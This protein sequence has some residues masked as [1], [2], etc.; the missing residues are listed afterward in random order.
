MCSLDHLH[1]DDEQ[2]DEEDE[3]HSDSAILMQTSHIPLALSDVVHGAGWTRRDAA[4]WKKTQ[5]I[6]EL[7]TYHYLD[8]HI[9][10]STLTLQYITLSLSWSWSLLL[11]TTKNITVSY[12][13]S[14]RT[15]DL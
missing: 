15:A 3:Q 2:Q 13:A 7:I 5:R 10:Q 11:S 1:N 14:K 12:H 6:I 4:L 9:S 8:I